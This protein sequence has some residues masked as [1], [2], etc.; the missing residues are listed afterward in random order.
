MSTHASG[1][2][3]FI[4]QLTGQERVSGAFAIANAQIGRTRQ[5]KPYLRCLLRD[6]TGEL[7][8]RMWSI[9]EQTFRRLPTEGFVWVEGETQPYQGDL[10]L[11]I[12]NIDPI[13]PSPEQLTEL[14]P[15]TDK[16]VNAMFAEVKKILG[17][18][19][20]PAMKAL[21]ETYLADEYLM[22]RFR[23]APAAKSMHHAYLGGLLEHTLNL[24]RLASLVCPLYPK[25]NKDIVVF[26]LFI[27]DLGKTRELVYDKSFSY[28]DMGELVGHIVEGAHMLRDKV[29]EMIHSTGQRLPAGT[30]L[31]LEHIVLSHHGIPEYGAAKIPATPE[32]ILVSMLDNV[33]AKTTIAIEAARPDREAQ[34]DLGGNF[35]QKQWALDTKLYRPDPL[36]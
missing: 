19:E 3:R 15:T 10:Q 22:D 25:I 36:A 24:M 33:D 20:H 6:K 4:N 12:H 8:G 2:R 35:T 14:L 17:E 26:G 34:F 28:S 23:L 27:H 5:D 29:Q 9:D 11:I 21:A 16:D 31:V 18:L 32:A 30:A 13:E 7:S 1:P